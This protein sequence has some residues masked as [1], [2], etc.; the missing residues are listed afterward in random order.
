[1]VLGGWG[2]GAPIQ[3]VSMKLRTFAKIISNVLDFR[4]AISGVYRLKGHWLTNAQTATIFKGSC[5]GHY[6]LTFALLLW[7]AI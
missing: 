4:H 7:H 6:S 3:P 1:M 2:G 5:C